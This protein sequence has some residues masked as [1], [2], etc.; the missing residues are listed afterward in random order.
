MWF[1]FGV[2]SSWTLTLLLSPPPSP[3]QAGARRS[4]AS[5]ARPKVGESRRFR[6]ISA[7]DLGG[8]AR[9]EQNGRVGLHYHALPPPVLPG[10]GSTGLISG[11]STS[12][13][14]TPCVARDRKSTRLNSSHGHISHAV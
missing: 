14:T 5:R 11:P 13:G 8:G 4:S 9:A 2:Q 7:S 10:S 12:R 1:V 6:R 3:P